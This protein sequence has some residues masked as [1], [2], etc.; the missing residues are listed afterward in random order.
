[1]AEQQ[2][3][4]LAKSDRGVKKSSVCCLIVVFIV[5]ILIYLFSLLNC[6]VLPE[7]VKIILNIIS[8][9]IICAILP[10]LC[11]RMLTRDNI[12]KD[13]YYFLVQLP[14]AL[15]PLGMLGQYESFYSSSNYLCVSISTLVIILIA[16]IFTCCELK[17][18][19]VKHIKYLKCANLILAAI[20]T[21]VSLLIGQIRS[22]IESLL[23]I[24]FYSPILI[25]QAIYEK[26]IVLDECGKKD[27]EEKEPQKS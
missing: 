27:K 18:I 15:F 19:D 26:M 4:D 9:S 2:G 13:I 20:V 12:E 25:L 8:I 5:A 22:E 10:P 3:N 17:K 1:M 14:Y 11:F 6:N 16:S 24:S 21:I 23:M 7:Y